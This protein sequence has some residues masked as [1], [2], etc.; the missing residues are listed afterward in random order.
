[1]TFLAAVL[2]TALLAPVFLIGFGITHW[3]AGERWLPGLLFSTA[4]TLVVYAFSLFW[5]VVPVD[6]AK[7][8]GDEAVRWP[9]GADSFEQS[10]FPLTATCHWKSGLS[11]SLVPPFVNPVI[12]ACMAITVVCAAM[13]IVHHRRN[14][15][16]RRSGAAHSSAPP[17]SSAADNGGNTS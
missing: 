6:F 7:T 13:T 16:S 5:F 4:A 17:R 2:L 11:H 1:M 14:Q 15:H 8:C 9:R 12:Y 10:A 3:R